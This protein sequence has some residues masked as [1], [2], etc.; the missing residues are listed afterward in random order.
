MCVTIEWA[1]RSFSLHTSAA[2]IVFPTNY[3]STDVQELMGLKDAISRASRNTP[4]YDFLRNTYLRLFNRPE[5]KVRERTT[6]FYSQFVTPE[7]LVFDVGANDGDYTRIFVAL[8]ARV[9]SVEPNPQLTH[10]LKE[11]RPFDRVKIEAAAVGSTNGSAELFLCGHD[12]LS[13]LSQDWVEIAEKSER[14]SGIKWDQKITVPVV[15]LDSLVEK[16]G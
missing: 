7:D 11:I 15:T 13:T 6:F 9:V 8:G 4:A 2:A 3:L 12:V 10:V 5:W 14:F 1:I 16:Y